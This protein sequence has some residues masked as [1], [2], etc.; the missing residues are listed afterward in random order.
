MSDNTD[1]IRRDLGK[2]LKSKMFPLTE[3]KIEDT[4]FYYQILCNHDNRNDP[5]EP[6]KHI[7]TPV[8]YLLNFGE[9][10]L[11]ES[12]FEGVPSKVL[13]FVVD[14]LVRS[15][16]ESELLKAKIYCDRFNKLIDQANSANKANRDSY[17]EYYSEVVGTAAVTTAQNQN[18]PN[19]VNERNEDEFDVDSFIFGVGF[20]QTS[21]Q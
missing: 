17:S 5:Q 7:K 19:R 3:E 6:Y 14:D 15:A 21:N 9:Y 2:W 10:L 8:Q 12:E 20:R 16:S 18:R 4:Y 13:C 11:K 1:N